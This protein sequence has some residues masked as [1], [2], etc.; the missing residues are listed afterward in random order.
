[1]NKKLDYV[2]ASKLR[3]FLECPQKLYYKY[4]EGIEE[5]EKTVMI[6]GKAFHE[7]ILEGKNDEAF[8]SLSK[9]YKSRIDEMQ[10]ALEREP[11]WKPGKLEKAEYE[12]DVKMK[13]G[14]T[15]KVIIDRLGEF[16]G[17]NAI[18]ELKSTGNLQRWDWW[19]AENSLQPYIYPYAY[20][21]KTGKI[22][23]FYFVIVT[24]D[25]K[26]KCKF[27]RKQCTEDDF[28]LLEEQLTLLQNSIDTEMWAADPQERKCQECPYFRE[29]PAAR[30][31]EYY[32][33]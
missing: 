25:P 15:V 13:N 19:F 28:K 16:N 11:L 10:E 26:P 29:C 9:T 4:V 18:V 5:E 21:L 3:L 20:W 23:P 32:S 22:L 30:Q 17:E 31:K 8:E 33:F 6:I 7:R 1:M 27:F 12:F 24:F 2:S 14:T